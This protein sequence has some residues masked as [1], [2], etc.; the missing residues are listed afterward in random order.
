VPNFCPLGLKRCAL[1]VAK[2]VECGGVFAQLLGTLWLLSP[3]DRQ[4]VKALTV[5]KFR[6]DLRLFDRG[7]ELLQMHGKVP[8]LGV[9]P[10]IDRL[11]LPEEDAA[12][13]PT[14]L[15]TP[16]DADAAP[17]STLDVV[18]IQLP[19][20][21][22]FDGFDPLSGEPGVRVRTRG[23]RLRSRHGF[24]TPVMV[25]VRKRTGLTALARQTDASGAVTSTDFFTMTLSG[26][27]GCAPSACNRAAAKQATRTM[28]SLFRSIVWHTDSGARASLGQALRMHKGPRPRGNRHRGQRVF[29]A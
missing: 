8:V 13:L 18:V 27:V 20:L 14:E 29:L 24:G 23:R 9:L 25:P 12:R 5:N 21:S 26:Q 6:G 16:L 7:R 15:R 10:W 3:E 19:R 28:P 11:R 1:Q 22:N 4:R 17:Q 2:A